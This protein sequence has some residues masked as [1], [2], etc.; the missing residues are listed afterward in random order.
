MPFFTLI[1]IRST[2]QI[3]MRAALQ[4]E[5]EGFVYSAQKTCQIL[6]ARGSYLSL[7]LV[8]MHKSDGIGD[9]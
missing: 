8:N 1:R 2:E 3:A 4:N 5:V 9:N 7:L 6:G